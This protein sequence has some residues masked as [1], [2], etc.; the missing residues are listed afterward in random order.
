[1]IAPIK[2]FIRIESKTRRASA[3]EFSFPKKPEKKK[4]YENSRI[5]SP[6]REGIVVAT[7]IKGI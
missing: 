1:M 4:T 6:P 5:P 3:K 7:H 2:L